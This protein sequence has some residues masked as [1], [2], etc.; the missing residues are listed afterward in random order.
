M[1]WTYKNWKHVLDVPG[2]GRSCLMSRPMTTLPASV[3]MPFDVN[4]TRGCYIMKNV[5][6]KIKR[7]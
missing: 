4:T 3:I 1:S 7:Y 5:F 6:F 2:T